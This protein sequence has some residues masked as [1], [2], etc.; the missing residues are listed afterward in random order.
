MT[1][2]STYSYGLPICS[3][4]SLLHLINTIFKFTDRDGF[5]PDRAKNNHTIKYS[6]PIM[7]STTKEEFG[8]WGGKTIKGRTKLS[9][10]VNLSFF[11]EK[12]LENE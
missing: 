5:C 9:L 11:Y 6:I 8:D 1:S 3:S 7:T 4:S 2:S 12:P 10:D